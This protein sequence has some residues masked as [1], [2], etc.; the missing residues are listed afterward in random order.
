MRTTKR[1][2]VG[3]PLTPEALRKMSAKAVSD[4]QKEVEAAQALGEKFVRRAFETVMAESAREG[5]TKATVQ[6]E[7][8]RCFLP[9]ALESS[10]MSSGRLLTLIS[11]V[12]QEL[13][14]RGFAV[15]F[16]RV[17]VMGRLHSSRDNPGDD[18]EVVVDWNP[19]KSP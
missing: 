16:Q 9:D 8:V 11:L 10:L 4:V 17:D 3:T 18:Q 7:R 1:N 12:A 14:D 15:G 6:L 2:G 5:N 19:E 13:R